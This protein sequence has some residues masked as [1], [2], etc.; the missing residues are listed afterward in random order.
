MNYRLFPCR[1]AKIAHLVTHF[2]TV[3]SNRQW[4]E[5]RSMIPSGRQYMLVI[6][7]GSVR[8]RT[9][10]GEQAAGKGVS[11][12]AIH[13][14]C[15]SADF[16]KDSL[17]LAV[18][19]RPNALHKLY[20]KRFGRKDFFVADSGTFP[21]AGELRPLYLRVKATE[22]ME[23]RIAALEQYF[24]S[25]TAASPERDIVDDFLDFMG[26]WRQEISTPQIAHSLHTNQ[27]SLELKFAAITGITPGRYIRLMR[28]IHLFRDFARGDCS[29]RELT[30][31]YNYIDYSHLCRDFRKYTGVSLKDS[32][33]P[34]E[35]LYYAYLDA[36]GIS[37][38]PNI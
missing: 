26:D 16:E 32:R 12:Q 4:V 9:S 27:R 24:E 17:I 2:F 14:F 22:N 23:E 37:L 33:I 31:R 15:Y 7:S 1:S 13:D 30:L 8:F 18:S 11:L 6:L 10:F 36:S 35:S 25:K 34:P 20:G 5:H 29:I 38:T 19:L 21:G 3:S 28:F